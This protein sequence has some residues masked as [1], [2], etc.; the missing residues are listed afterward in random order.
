MRVR[1]ARKCVF[2]KEIFIFNII[3]FVK[4]NVL[5]FLHNRLIFFFYFFSIF[6]ISKVVYVR[7][8]KYSVIGLNL[9]CGS[10]KIK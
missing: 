1:F 9:S 7:G 5:L 4:A 6:I 2:L 10:Y 3:V 8:T